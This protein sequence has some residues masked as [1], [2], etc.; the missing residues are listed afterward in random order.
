VNIHVADEAPTPGCSTLNSSTK[1]PF[2]VTDCVPETP[3][4]PLVLDV[5]VVEQIISVWSDAGGLVGDDAMRAEIVAL[6]EWKKVA[7]AE[8]A[9]YRKLRGAIA[10]TLDMGA[11][12]EPRSG[13]VRPRPWPGAGN[14]RDLRK[15]TPLELMEIAE[16]C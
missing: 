4:Y 14:P 9:D 10:M 12:Y 11:V 5:D 6:R 3:G 8:I 16:S 7:T 15:P 1:G 2:V 13:R